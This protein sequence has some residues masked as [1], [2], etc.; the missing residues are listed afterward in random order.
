MRRADGTLQRLD[1]RYFAQVPFPNK[2]VRANS[3]VTFLRK[4]PWVFLAL[5][6][7]VGTAIDVLTK[8]W[9]V[10]AIQPR[11]QIH[12]IGNLLSFVLVHNRGA[13]F[14][15]DPRA[16]IPGFPVNVFFTVFNLIAVSLIVFYYNAVKGR[17]QIAQWGLA[18]VVPGAFGNLSDRLLRPAQGVVDFIMVDLGFPPAD[19]WPVFNFADIYVSVG[20]G[21]ILLSM[22]R[23]EMRRRGQASQPE[24]TP[25]TTPGAPSGP[26]PE[27]STPAEG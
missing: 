11:E 14:G 10:H 24:Q 1:L 3:H 18:I 19:P 16:L 6:A 2:A 7:V 5:V 9:A 13:I 22:L 25:A 27:S 20:V 23:D 8:S 4:H 15:I 21:L 17:D 26:E 12:I